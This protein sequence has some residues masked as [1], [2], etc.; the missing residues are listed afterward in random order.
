MTTPVPLPYTELSVKPYK[1]R[2]LGIDFETTVG[3][4]GIR[5]EAAWSD[6]ELSYTTNE[7]VPMPEVKWAAGADWSTGIWRITGE[8]NGKYI[9]E[10]GQTTVT[11]VIGTGPDYSQ[12]A[13]MLAI[14]GFDAEAYVKQQVGAFNRLYN[15]QLK[16]AYHAASLRVEA[17]IL[18][19]KILPSVLTMYNFTSRDLLIIPEIKIKP[20]DGLAITIGAEVYSGRKGSLYDLVDDFMNGAYVSLRVDF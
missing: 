11:P 15:N 7:Y 1:S 4:L 8:Y 12:F 2:V 19:G 3:V 18:Y 6:P 13:A 20:A 16:E 5:G 9:T 14:P 17:E 10:F